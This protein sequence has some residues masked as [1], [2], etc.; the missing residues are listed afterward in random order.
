MSALAVGCSS[1]STNYDYDRD[2]DFDSY[3]T[4]AWYEL[5]ANAAS[6]ARQAQQ[7]YVLLDKRIKNE[8]S[9]VRDVSQR[10]LIRYRDQMSERDFILNPVIYIC[11]YVKRDLRCH[12]FSAAFPDVRGDLK[13]Y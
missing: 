10:K 5:P 11:L 8:V 7:R 1:I 12:V 13:M 4:V 2:A 9:T 6:N 3:G